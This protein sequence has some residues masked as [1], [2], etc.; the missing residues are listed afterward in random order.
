MGLQIYR[1]LFWYGSSSLESTFEFYLS[2]IPN[3]GITTT[4]YWL[5]DIL[6][7]FLYHCVLPN[8]RRQILHGHQHRTERGTLHWQRWEK[9]E[10]E[11]KAEE[12]VW[13]MNDYLVLRHHLALPCP[14]IN[15]LEQGWCFR[16]V[17]VD[18]QLM[19]QSISRWLPQPQPPPPPSDVRLP[20][21]GGGNE[22]VP[23]G[24]EQAGFGVEWRKQ[25]CSCRWW[26]A[27][28]SP[29]QKSTTYVW[30]LAGT[31]TKAAF[32]SPNTTRAK[33]FSCHHHCRRRR[34]AAATPRRRRSKQAH[35]ERLRRHSSHE[36]KT[37]KRKHISKNMAIFQR[38]HLYSGIVQSEWVQGSNAAGFAH[39]I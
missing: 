26:R 9:Q 21:G 29:T 11:A 19:N 12:G 16:N 7:P 33:T 31:K 27:A 13:L 18:I 25:A 28:S 38:A 6:G 30:S 22:A 37:R 1:V 34:N 35:F 24:F 8:R 15:V 10:E 3:R 20:S 39:A 17:A 2:M 4:R 32:F 23:D 36:T 14:M 5:T